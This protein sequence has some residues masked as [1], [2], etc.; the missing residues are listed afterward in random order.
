MAAPT[1][2]TQPASAAVMRMSRFM[3]SIG[4]AGILAA[5][6]GVDYTDDSAQSQDAL[7]ASNGD[8]AK[9]SSADGDRR[10]SEL[11]RFEKDPGATKPQCEVAEDCYGQGIITPQCVGAFKCEKNQCLWICGEP[12]I[13]DEP[14]TCGSVV[15]DY[16][17]VCCNSSCGVCTKPGDQCTQQVC[18]QPPI[19]DEPVVTCGSVTCAAGEVCCNSSC[20]VCT[21]PGDQC[22]QQ[23]CDEPL[24]M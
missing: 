13:T 12:P 9:R 7:A 17:E 11:P 23:I 10:P 2:G 5:C 16:G 3:I 15:C 22:T 8:S 24:P 18:E 20:G 19:T 1:R 21:K 4:L 6:T 14:V